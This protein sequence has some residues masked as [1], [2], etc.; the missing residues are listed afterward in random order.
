[1]VI[2]MLTDPRGVDLDY[3]RPL[4]QTEE[5]A[6]LD[7]R[8]ASALSRMGILMTNTCINYQTI[9]P[10]V[11]GDHV[12]FG[13]TGV[14]IYS[15]SVCGARSNF[16]SGPSALALSATRVFLGAEKKPAG[17]CTINCPANASA[18]TAALQRNLDWVSKG[19]WFVERFNAVSHDDLQVDALPGATSRTEKACF[20]SHRNVLK[21]TIRAFPGLTVHVMEDDVVIGERTYA[22]IDKM[23]ASGEQH[24]KGWDLI[25][26]D[27]VIPH[28]WTMQQLLV[29]RRYLQQAD[30][31]EILDLARLPFAGTTSYVATAPG[32]RKLLDLMERLKNLSQPFDLQV[33]LWI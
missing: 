19:S 13:D 15:N 23:L 12:A 30:H 6:D 31:L 32:S 21:E 29:K 10:P 33:R 2:P 11:L 20:L 22:I 24:E 18:R 7:R 8:T 9:M 16:E 25:F 5:M 17:Y 3:Y 26:T 27:V 28:L 1:M 4:G 14:V